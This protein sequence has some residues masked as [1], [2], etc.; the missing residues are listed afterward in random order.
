MG[1][2]IVLA[3]LAA[4]IAMFVWESV[5]HLLLPLGEVGVKRIGNEDAVMTALRG[6]IPE[7][8]F[9]FFPAAEVQPGMT[10]GQKQAA[11]QAA[12]EKYR[13]GPSGVLIYRPGGAEALSPRQLAG[14]LGADIA[15]MLV[16]AVL[17]ARIAG[18]AGYG[19]RVLVVTL[20]GLLPVLTVDFSYW[21]WY[22]F[23]ADYT[24]A[25]L[26]GTVIGF[27]VGGLVLAAILKPRTRAA[28]TS[29]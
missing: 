19:G 7:P 12:M 24:L 1:K 23:P 9:Y 22:G 11:M 26:A 14:Q 4:G 6:N 17:L 13:T 8:G 3:G 29:A 20:M 27:L 5:S 2:R 28:Q 16:A 15:A 21:N 18:G 25:Q 10:A